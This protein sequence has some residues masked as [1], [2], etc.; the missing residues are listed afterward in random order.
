MRDI[1]LEAMVR[2]SKPKK[3]RKKF[4]PLVPEERSELNME[5]LNECVME[6]YI[7]PARYRR[8]KS[9]G[10]KKLA[11]PKSGRTRVKF[12]RP[13]TTNDIFPISPFALK[14]KPSANIKKMA[15]PKKDYGER[16]RANAFQVPKKA[17]SKLSKA[18]Q[19]YYTEMAMPPK[20][21]V[22]PKLEK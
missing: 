16:P 5:Y 19:T 22:I 1:H 4:D 6:E 15:K 9:M 14:Y 2:L 20:W 3:P 17:L 18:K 11:T 13:A 8:I 12:V 7:P 21:K 10:Y